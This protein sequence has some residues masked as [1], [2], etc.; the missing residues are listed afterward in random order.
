MGK[1]RFLKRELFIQEIFIEYLYVPGI[2][3]CW[4]TM[5]DKS[6][7]GPFYMKVIVKQEFS[8]ISLIIMYI[9]IL[10]QVCILLFTQFPI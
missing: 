9:F 2:A 8:I 1:K 5:V 7:M 10:I 4:A 3:A 6:N